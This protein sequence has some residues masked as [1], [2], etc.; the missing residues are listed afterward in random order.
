MGFKERLATCGFITGAVL[1]GVST[2]IE[3]QEIRYTSGGCK[4][5]IYV[6]ED[7][8][9]GKTLPALNFR[10][11]LIFTGNDPSNN[12]MRHE[13]GHAD[14]LCEQGFGAVTDWATNNKAHEEDATI[15]GEDY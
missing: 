7:M 6:V 13:M 3:P 14:Q 2:S 4:V 15:R 11:A 10:D 9:G 5:N 8:K 12:L 1:L